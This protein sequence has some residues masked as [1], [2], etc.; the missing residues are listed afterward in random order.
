MVDGLRVASKALMIEVHYYS[1][2][3]FTG[4]WG[5]P[6]ASIRH[7]VSTTSQS[8][9]QYY[10]LTGLRVAADTKGLLITGGKKIIIK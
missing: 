5:G 10:T 2:P 4:V 6:T 7:T 3:Q 8:A 9:G 1:P